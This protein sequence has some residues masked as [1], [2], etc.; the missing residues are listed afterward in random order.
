MKNNVVI[1][2][3]FYIFFTKTQLNII[4]TKFCGNFHKIE[5]INLIAKN[6]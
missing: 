4:E 5:Q 2:L 6:N 3:I 1:K